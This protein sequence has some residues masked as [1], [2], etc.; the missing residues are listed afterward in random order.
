MQP[1]EAVAVTENRSCH[2]MLRL[3]LHNRKKTR[4]QFCAGKSSAC[5][6]FRVA[7]ICGQNDFALLMVR[8]ND[9]NVDA[10]SAVFLYRF[11]SEVRLSGT[12]KIVES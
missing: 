2:Q 5:L 7:S 10:I 4:S 1:L 3:I 12:V 9:R 8:S 6:N 11:G